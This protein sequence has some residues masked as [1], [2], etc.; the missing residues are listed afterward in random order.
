MKPRAFVNLDYNASN[1]MSFFFLYL[2]FQVSL[3]YPHPQQLGLAQQPHQAPHNQQQQQPLNAQMISHP[4]HTH[5]HPHHHQVVAA[6]SQQQQQQLQS[7]QVAAHAAVLQC[8]QFHQQQQ[9]VFASPSAAGSATGGRGQYRG[10]GGNPCLG[11]TQTAH[12]Q[13]QQQGPFSLSSFAPC[14]YGP[15]PQMIGPSPYPPPPPPSYQTVAPP[16]QQARQT[17]QQQQHSHH[18]Q[19]QHQAAL[20]ADHLFQHSM[21]ALQAASSP[22][23]QQPITANVQ[24][25]FTNYPPSAAASSTAPSSLPPPPNYHYHQQ[26]QQQ[27]QQHQ[28]HFLDSSSPMRNNR[29]RNPSSG[30]R[31]SLQ[32]QRR[33]WRHTGP[34]T[35][36]QGVAM[37]PMGG[38]TPQTGG[39]GGLAIPL[40]A[41]AAASVLHSAYPPGFLLS[42]LSMLSSTQLHPGF[43]NAD[44]NEP[45][46][47]EALLNLAERLGEV[48]PKGLSKADIEQLPSYR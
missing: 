31:R 2:P 9:H 27:Q 20:Q 24:P 40:Q 43:G 8:Q 28:M 21:A 45:E 13:Q 38:A 3:P 16:P 33:S 29:L 41:A 17:P 11:P 15:P 30:N 48:K 22:F 5:H 37:P 44:V 39:T 47:Y 12:S 18:R 10:G 14:N 25:A 6:A 46:N 36:S 1:L 23:G 19:Q 7:A 32:P 35:V 42:V 34:P 26:Q 4:P